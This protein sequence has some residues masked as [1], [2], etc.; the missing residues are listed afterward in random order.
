MELDKR[1]EGLEGEI[2]L[3]KGELKGTLMGIRDLLQTLEVPAFGTELKA[4]IDVSTQSSG[5]EPSGMGSPGG[6]PPLNDSA[7]LQE[8]AP[9]GPAPLQEMPSQVPAP[10]QAMPSPGP[11]PLGDLPLEEVAPLDDFPLDEAAQLD[12]FPLEGP[13]PLGDVPLEGPAPLDDIP[14]AG[15]LP[16]DIP[17]GPA[18]FQEIYSSPQ[19]EVS[20]LPE[21]PS[22][23]PAE[24]RQPEEARDGGPKETRKEEMMMGKGEGGQYV[25]QANLFANLICWVAAAKKEIGDELL[26][27]FL[28]AYGIGEQLPRQLRESILHL[29][30][31]IEPGTVKTDKANI[32]SRLMLELHGILAGGGTSPSAWRPFLNGSEKAEEDADENGQENRPI[33]LKLALPTADG[34]EREFSISLTPEPNGD[35]DQGKPPPSGGAVRKNG[36][37]DQKKIPPSGGAGRKKG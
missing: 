7:P 3:I 22:P 30:D 8:M 18:P 29:A 16:E 35:A 9:E 24:S 25:S 14:L 17:D 5:S 10:S 4:S 26:P 33:K 31:M 34:T 37:A 19:D 1:I 36:D 6:A 32:W 20:D 27:A 12:D 11:A 23:P 28:D 15:P 2:K 21:D 13:A